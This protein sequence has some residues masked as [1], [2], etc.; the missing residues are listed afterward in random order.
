M[1]QGYGVEVSLLDK[2]VAGRLVSGKSVVIEALYRRLITPRGSLGSTVFPEDL[3][4]GFD[5]SAFVGAVG[6]ERA[7]NVIGGMAAN[8]LSKDDRVQSVVCT[9]TLSEDGTLLLLDVDGILVDSD[10]TFSLTL[11]VSDVSVELLAAS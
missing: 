6:Y 3:I 11:G 7:A 9:A 10:E 2:L 5:V 8:E 1:A 4:Y